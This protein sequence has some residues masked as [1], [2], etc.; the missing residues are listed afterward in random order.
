MTKA[1]PIPPRRVILRRPQVE[2]KTGLA[3]ST[4]YKLISDGLFPRPV[5][6]GSRSVGWLE[7]EVDAWIESRTRMVPRRAAAADNEAA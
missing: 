5:N 6:L 3:R 2:E 1:N 4:L 7:G